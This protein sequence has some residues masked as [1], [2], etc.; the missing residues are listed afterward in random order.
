MRLYHVSEDPDI[1]VFHPRLPNRDDLD[2]ATGLVWA[3][4]EERLPKFLTPRDCPRCQE[5]WQQDI[6][7][8]P[9]AFFLFQ[10]GTACAGYRAEVV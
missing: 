8:G 4:D 9:G 6:G 3:L 2:P 1:L 5:I 10:P 7:R